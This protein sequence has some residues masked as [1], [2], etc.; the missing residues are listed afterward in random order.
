[1]TPPNSE[2]KIELHFVE[3]ATRTLE[4]HPELRDEARGE[5]MDGPARAFQ[6]EG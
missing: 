4:A 2:S 3:L 5:L 6:G 1:M